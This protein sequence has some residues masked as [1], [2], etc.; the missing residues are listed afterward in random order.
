MKKIAVIDIG[1]NSIKLL[2]AEVS[3]ITGIK[4]IIHRQKITRLGENFNADK[5]LK[6]EPI[7]RTIS[8]LEDFKTLAISLGAVKI[9]SIATAALRSAKNPEIF[10]EKSDKISMKPIVLSSKEEGILGRIGASLEFKPENKPLVTLDIGGGSTELSF[11]EEDAVSLPIGAVVLTEKFI[12]TDPPAKKEIRSMEKFIGKNLKTLDPFKNFFPPEV[13]PML[14]GVGGTILTISAINLKLESYISEK[15]HRSV[16]LYEKLDE[17]LS[18]LSCLKL[19]E[20][21][22]VA[23]LGFR[24]IADIVGGGKILKKTMDYLNVKKCHVSEFSLLQGILAVTELKNV[25]T[26][27]PALKEKLT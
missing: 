13:K 24:F 8:A 23:G 26:C 9:I 20:R 18:K 17:I 11:S 19:E 5:I 15:I 3:E 12:R 14:V 21:K 16:I 22:K 25:S 6:S 10:L 4:K 1:T 7:E 2:V 27:T